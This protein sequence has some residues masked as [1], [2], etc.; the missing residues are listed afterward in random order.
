MRTSPT[1]LHSFCCRHLELQV[2]IPRIL[3]VSQT[4]KRRA[5][6]QRLAARDDGYEREPSFSLLSQ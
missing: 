5:S 2:E 3:E 1:L 6:T 4:P